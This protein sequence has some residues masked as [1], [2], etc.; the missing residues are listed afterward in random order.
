L[1]QIDSELF[2]MNLS[3]KTSEHAKDTK[4]TASHDIGGYEVIRTLGEGGFG[5]VR[6]VKEKSSDKRHGGKE[7]GFCYESD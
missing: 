5:V 2:D 7:T 1:N 4:P 3:S 6:L